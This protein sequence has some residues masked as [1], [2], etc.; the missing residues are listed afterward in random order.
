MEGENLC[1]KLGEPQPKT[2]GQVASGF[3][4]RFF[5]SGGIEAT[6]YGSTIMST[7]Q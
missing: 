4:P 7:H 2:E 5:W 1:Q 6:H 3:D